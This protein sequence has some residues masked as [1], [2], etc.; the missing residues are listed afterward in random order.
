MREKG[1]NIDAMVA[2]RNLLLALGYDADHDENF[3]DTPKRVEKL[4]RE[5]LN[6]K[7]EIRDGIKNILGKKFPS[8]YQGMVTAKNIHT[9]SFCPHHLLPVKYTIDLG[10]IPK[11]KMLG[12]SKLARLADLFSKQLI[13]QEELTSKIAN[14]LYHDMKSS[15]AIC[16]IKGEH[17]CMRIRGVEQDD[18]CVITSE[19]RGVFEKDGK[20][21]D[22]FFKLIKQ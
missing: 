4:Y 10:Y 1:T 15:G 21:R 14:S 13:L 19:V 3:R 11:G 18:S 8:S 5:M 9:I 6:D 7:Y 16:I 2:V 20:A 22:E 17:D 12:L